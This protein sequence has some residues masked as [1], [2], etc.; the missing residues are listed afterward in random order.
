MEGGG[1]SQSSNSATT[2]CI[3]GTSA[4]LPVSDHQDMF[5]APTESDEMARAAAFAYYGYESVQVDC[6]QNDEDDHGSLISHTRRYSS[7]CEGFDCA[8]EADDSGSSQGNDPIMLPLRPGSISS[9]SSSHSSLGGRFDFR[10]RSSNLSSPPLPSIV[11]CNSG[12]STTQRRHGAIFQDLLQSAGTVAMVESDASVKVPVFAFEFDST[13][14]STTSTRGHCRSVESAASRKRGR[15]GTIQK[16]PPDRPRSVDDVPDSSRRLGTQD[17]ATDQELASALNR[18]V[19]IRANE[20]ISIDQASPQSVLPATSISGS[21]NYPLFPLGTSDLCGTPMVSPESSRATFLAS[22]ADPM[23]SSDNYSEYDDDTRDLP[24]RR[25]QRRK[26]HE[27]F[28][29][30][31]G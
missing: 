18:S 15:R 27:D 30:A 2:P 14:T 4:P 24:I 22:R 5:L 8:G 29:S 20:A 26:S 1:G 23:G 16:P 19:A 11:G 3:T 17:M 21:M 31:R 13:A 9:S 10:W 12:S 7:S 6:E 25:V 28:P